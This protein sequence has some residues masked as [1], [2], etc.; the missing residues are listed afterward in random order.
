MKNL[1]LISC[2]FFS[3]TTFAQNLV[4]NPSF[5]E[6]DL[7]FCG[8]MYPSDFNSAAVEWYTPGGGSPDMY[9]TNINDT[10][11]NFQP[12]SNYAGPIGIKGSQLPRTGEIM[13]GFG[14]FTIQGMEQREY[15]QVPL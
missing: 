6:T 7:F 9:Y 3:I 8:I 4:P 1:F 12:N 13:S 5:E 10:C 14:A 15:I 2:L 11:F